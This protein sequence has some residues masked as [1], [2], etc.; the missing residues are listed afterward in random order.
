MY[1][2]RAR[3]LALAAWL[4]P[5]GCPDSGSAVQPFGQLA[6]CAFIIIDEGKCIRATRVNMEDSRM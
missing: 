5:E 1:E 2:I 4:R 6:Y 3:G